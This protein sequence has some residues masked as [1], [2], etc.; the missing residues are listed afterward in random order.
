MPPTRIYSL[1]EKEKI[2]HILLVNNNNNINSY[3]SK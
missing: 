2:L 3:I 1:I